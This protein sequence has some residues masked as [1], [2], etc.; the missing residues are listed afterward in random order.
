MPPCGLLQVVYQL[1]VSSGTVVIMLS[2]SSIKHVHLGMVDLSLYFSAAC[3]ITSD[4][5]LSDA[6]SVSRYDGC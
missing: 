5:V 1:R 3:L 6:P 4:E 2:L